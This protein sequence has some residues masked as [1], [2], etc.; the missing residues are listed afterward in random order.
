MNTDLLILGAGPGGYV[1][2]IRSGRM[3]IK[4]TLVEKHKIGGVCLNYGCIPTKVLLS[5]TALLSAVKKGKRY[6]LTC[7]GLN[8][9]YAKLSS[10]KDR[11]V[12]G[13]VKGI[14]LLLKD[15]GVE[16]LREEGNFRDDHKLELSSG[17][18]V[19]FRNAIIATGSRNRNLP[20]IEVDGTEIIDSTSALALTE[21]P[22]SMLV[23]GAGAIGLELALIFSRLGTKTTVVE[24]MPEILPGMDSELAEML[25]NTLTRDGIKFYLGV[26]VEKIEKSGTGVKA[27]V[28][29]MDKPIE[30]EKVLLA[31]GRT[32]NTEPLAK[33]NL[34]TI[35]GGFLKVD[36]SLNTSIPN[37]KAIGD[38]AGM[39]LLAHKASHE[40]IMAVEM[41]GGLK[42]EAGIPPIPG[43]VFTE[44]EFASV[45]LT[46]AQAEERGLKAVESVF[47]LQAVSRARTIDASVGAFKIVTDSSDRIIGVHILSPDAGD[48]IAEASLAIRLGLKPK[49]L[50]ETIHVHPTLSEGLMEAALLADGRRIHI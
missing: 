24:L 32:P 35:R 14:E 2:G 16:I 21:I 25:R 12:D 47:P 20:H 46:L 13:L 1:A 31:V 45:G 23:I 27:F 36:R 17:D 29:G 4:T 19:E 5:K 33:L 22:S 18:I 50:A 48:I 6:G 26:S 41:F 40:G 37:I 38:V 39:P 43:A 34:E 3:G 28:T 42:H 7:E 9:D 30:V 10:Y 44:P 49:D 11:V 15:A 8:L